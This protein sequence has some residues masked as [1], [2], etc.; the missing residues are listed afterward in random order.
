MLVPSYLKLFQSGE[1]LERIEMLN[2]KLQECNLCPRRCGVNRTD[3]ELGY[4]KGGRD[5]VVSSAFSHFGEEL[6]LVGVSGSGTIFLTHCNLRCVFCQNYDISHLGSGNFISAKEVAKTMV[7]LQDMGCQNIN[8]VTPTHYV[9]QI[10]EALPL[11]IKMG[12]NLPLVFNCGGYELVEVLELLDGIFDIYMPDMKFMNGN[13]SRKYCGASDYPAIVK[14]AVKEMHR[15]V[16][17]ADINTNGIMEKGLLVRHLVMP[18]GLAG[19]SD[20]FRFIAEE[21]SKDTYINIMAQYYP[22]Y[23]AN[24][25]EEISRRITVKEYKDA[26]EQAKEYGLHRGFIK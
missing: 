2:S 20:C 4:C 12:L 16:G 3:G 18:N 26:I 22:C 5:L 9:P 15:Q 6:P 23:E 13:V 11:A 24:K 10:V 14:A 21:I 1:L 7:R 17:D 25:Y 8:F 19:S